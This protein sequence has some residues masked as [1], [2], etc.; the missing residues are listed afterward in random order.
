M[1][2][3]KIACPECGTELEQQQ[4]QAGF[5]YY[6]CFS[7]DIWIPTKSGFPLLAGAKKHGELMTPRTHTVFP[8][9]VAPPPPPPPSPPQSAAAGAAIPQDCQNEVMSALL[10]R[11]SSQLDAMQEILME[12]KKRPIEEVQQSDDALLPPKKK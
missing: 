10:K 5:L 3:Y 8:S 4:S 6:K 2:N 9:R 7:C 1:S 12:V 11:F